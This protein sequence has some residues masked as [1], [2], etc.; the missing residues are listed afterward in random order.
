[1]HG[2]DHCC[3]VGVLHVHHKRQTAGYGTGSKS[4]NG[5]CQG[6]RKLLRHIGIDIR[7]SVMSLSGLTG[8]HAQTHGKTHRP[9]G[10]PLPADKKSEASAGTYGGD[11]TV[12]PSEPPSFLP[13]IPPCPEIRLPHRYLPE[14][15]GP[16]RQKGRHG[17]AARR[18]AVYPLLPHDLFRCAICPV[19]LPAQG[20]SPFRLKAG[21]AD[22]IVDGFKLFGQS[23]PPVAC[24]VGIGASL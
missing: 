3:A 11:G 24:R 21:P 13:G 15:P 16:P 20:N 18:R 10:I 22:L 1:M 23:I 5:V 6:G 14:Q 9:P 4:G 8:E 12:F 19:C 7:M 17:S 2:H